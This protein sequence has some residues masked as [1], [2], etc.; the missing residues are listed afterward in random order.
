VT[1]SPPASC[2]VASFDGEWKIA[3]ELL[4]S[5]EPTGPEPVVRFLDRDASAAGHA[6]E[7]VV[8]TGA[9]DAR[10]TDALLERA[11]ARRPTALVLVETASFGPN[12]ARPARDPALLRLHAA[13][14]P[15]ATIRQGDDL[16]A[17]LSGFEEAYTAHG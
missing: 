5:A 17:K 15:V 3:L 2:H 9:L 8:V 13:G 11:L 12:G 1:S 16:A 7:L 6:A 10:L 14:V 4:A